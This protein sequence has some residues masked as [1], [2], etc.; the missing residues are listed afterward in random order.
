MDLREEVC[1]KVLLYSD[2]T[3]VFECDTEAANLGTSCVMR[4]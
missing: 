2:H 1:N 3:A 4:V